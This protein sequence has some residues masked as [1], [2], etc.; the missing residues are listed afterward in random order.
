MTLLYIVYIVEVSERSL[1]QEV[2]DI[3]IIGSFELITPPP[4]LI[5]LYSNS[6]RGKRQSLVENTRHTTKGSHI[7]LGLQGRRYRPGRPSNC[8]TNVKSAR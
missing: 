4:T 1:P 8:R 5:L 6:N 3:I 7:S 2:P